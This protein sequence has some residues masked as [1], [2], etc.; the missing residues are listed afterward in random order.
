MAA[1]SPPASLNAEPRAKFAADAK[2]KKERIGPLCP[3][4][5]LREAL[6]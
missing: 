6:R 3:L 1:K 2:V 5:P 4:R